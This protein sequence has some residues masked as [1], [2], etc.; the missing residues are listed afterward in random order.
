MQ[1]CY[2][3]KDRGT[4]PT[5]S[6]YCVATCCYTGYTGGEGGHSIMHAVTYIMYLNSGTIYG[7]LVYMY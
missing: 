2:E 1:R 7:L 6:V 4:K 5:T 3:V